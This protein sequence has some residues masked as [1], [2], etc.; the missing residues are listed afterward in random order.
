MIIK[1]KAIGAYLI[2]KNMKSYSWFMQCIFLQFSVEILR[3][4]LGA[5][6]GVTVWH[7]QYK[8]VFN[9]LIMDLTFS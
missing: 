3:G 7:M 9:S 5:T 2:C 6:V 1:Q 8:A 4:S